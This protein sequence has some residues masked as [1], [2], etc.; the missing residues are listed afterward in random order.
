MVCFDKNF[1]LFLIKIFLNTYFSPYRT[2][3]G[4]VSDWIGKRKKKKNQSRTRVQPRPQPLGA[5]MRIRLGCVD[6][7]SAPVLSRC[8]C[9]F[10][11]LMCNTCSF[12]CRGVCLLWIVHNDCFLRANVRALLFEEKGCSFDWWCLCEWRIGRLCQRWKT[13]KALISPQLKS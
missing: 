5:S 7:I 4:P 9:M 11:L 6:P 13:I 1:Y 3:L 2:D 12:E 8:I 10:L